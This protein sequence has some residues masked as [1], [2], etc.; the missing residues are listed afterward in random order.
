[1]STPTRKT[2]AA[3]QNA[4]HTDTIMRAVVATY[5]QRAGGPAARF[6]MTNGVNGGMNESTLATM[7]FGSF[8]T[9]T[10]NRIGTI[11]TIMTEKGYLARNKEGPSYVYRPRISEKVTT[12]RMLSDLIDRAFDGSASAVMLNLLETS[13]LDADELARL[14]GLINRKLKG[15]KS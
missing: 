15:D 2:L 12:R 4:A 8:V 1:M 11:M 6:I 10:M 13:D 9:R 14:R 3:A 7:P 5:S